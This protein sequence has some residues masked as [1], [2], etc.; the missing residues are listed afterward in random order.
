[1]NTRNFYLLLTLA[2]SLL[3]S[4]AALAWSANKINRE[5]A[6]ATKVFQEEVAGADVFLETAAGYLV[7]PRVIKVGLGFGAETSFVIPAAGRPVLMV[8]LR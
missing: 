3:V 1:M 2:G 8:R 5:V 7:F 4:G 6:E